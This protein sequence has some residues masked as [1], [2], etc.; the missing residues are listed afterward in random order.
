[1]QTTGFFVLPVVTATSSSAGFDSTVASLKVGLSWTSG[2]SMVPT[3][4]VVQATM[5]SL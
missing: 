1:L 2:A 3:V 4:Q 5:E